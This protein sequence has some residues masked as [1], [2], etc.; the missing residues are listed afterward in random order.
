MRCSAGRPG[1]APCTATGSTR[2]TPSRTP[3]DGELGDDTACRPNQIFAISLD[4]PVL[5]PEQWGQVLGTV[6]ERLLTRVGLRTLAPGHPDYKAT[7]SGDLRARDAAYHQGTV[8]PWLM[9]HFVD[10]WLRVYPDQVAQARRFLG[11]LAG[12][13]DEHC[14]GT[15]SE[16]YDA[17][18][19]YKPKGCVAQAWSVAE[20]LRSW[21]KTEQ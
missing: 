4:F 16:I 2:E 7:Y 3:P 6:R 14:I 9:G 10:A 13:L 20:M 19:P 12:S 8:W 15:I 18:E 21:L 11:G 17:E 5:A 1:L